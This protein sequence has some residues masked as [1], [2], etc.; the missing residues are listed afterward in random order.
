MN[1]P[2][3][4]AVETR[5]G[6]VFT[7]GSNSFLLSDQSDP[8]DLSTVVPARPVIVTFGHTTRFQDPATPA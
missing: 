8:S 6:S 2:Q 1:S 7:D 3:D 4:N 5:F